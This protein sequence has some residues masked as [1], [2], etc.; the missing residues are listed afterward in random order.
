[1]K[2]RRKSSEPSGAPVDE[3]VDQAIGGAAPGE[4]DQSAATG[5]WDVDDLPD[6]GIERVDL[7]SL[8]LANVDGLEIRLQVDESTNEVQSVVLAGAEGAVELRAFAAPRNGDLW[9]EIRPRI[10]AEYAQRGGTASER[11]GFYGTELVCQLTV[12]GEDGRTATQPSRVVGINGGRWMLRATLLG[13]AALEP[14]Q[15][16][17]WDEAIATTAVRRGAVAMPSGADLPLTLPPADQLT[18][19]GA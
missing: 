7:G 3:D 14:D 15:V 16:G 12:R 5:P 17:P 1:M 6:D 9:S 8:L 11:E 2:F 13:R 18:R 4:P 19:P 10:A